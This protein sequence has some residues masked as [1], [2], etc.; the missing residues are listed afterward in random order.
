[1]KQRDWVNEWEVANKETWIIFNQGG[2][3]F[4][5]V[6]SDEWRT[7]NKKPLFTM[8]KCDMTKTKPKATN[9]IWHKNVESWHENY[10]DARHAYYYTK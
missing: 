5:Q 1:M 10:E 8:C 4:G 7:N 2:R 9:N 3:C 6:L